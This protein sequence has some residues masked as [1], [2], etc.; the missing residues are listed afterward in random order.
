MANPAAPET[1]TRPFV[2]RF[3]LAA[4][5][6]LAALGIARWR[7]LEMAGPAL[8][9][10]SSVGASAICGLLTLRALRRPIQATMNAMALGALLRMALLAAVAF[11]TSWLDGNVL[12]ACAFFLGPILLLRVNEV[13]LIHGASLPAGTPPAPPSTPLPEHLS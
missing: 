3:G 11:L 12:A 9:V 4:L 1:L 2:A 7:G 8:A 13:L 5:L 6:S 10:L